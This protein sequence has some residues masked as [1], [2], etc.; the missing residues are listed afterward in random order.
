MRLGQ[1]DHER[2]RERR[3]ERH[4]ERLALAPLVLELGSLVFALREG[5]AQ[6]R[7]LGLELL[8][9]IEIAFSQPR[10]LGLELRAPPLLQ[11]QRGLLCDLRLGQRGLHSREV[12]VR[13]GLHPR[14]VCLRLGLHSREVCLHLQLCVQ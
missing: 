2:A 9:E 8:I 10:H 4:R 13:L 14:E 6:P 11:R 12:C 7:H 5:R 1:L 3:P